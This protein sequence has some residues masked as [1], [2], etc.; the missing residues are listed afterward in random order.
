MAI[1]L[2]KVI[3]K[4]VFLLSRH[5]LQ[6]PGL[7]ARGASRWSVPRLFAR[8]ESWAV[9]I[10]LLADLYSLPYRRVVAREIQLAG[11]GPDDRVLNIGCGAVPF[12]AIHLARMAG[13]RVTALDIDPAAVRKASLLI[14]RA[15]LSDQVTILEGDGAS[16]I[17]QGFD[18]A[19]VALQVR[20]KA[21]VLMELGRRGGRGSRAV[22]REPSEWCRGQYD[23]LGSLERL[24]SS[25]INH[26]M[27][28]LDRSVLVDLRLC[29]EDMEVAG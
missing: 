27:G 7:Y 4:R 5:V 10:P 2:I 25:Q 28:A 23:C 15:G 13:C 8:M 6:N 29:P 1:L 11:I 24:G 20:P 9:H 12:T 17:R 16:D 21:G 19:V 26:R 3:K 18:V 22:F 14:R